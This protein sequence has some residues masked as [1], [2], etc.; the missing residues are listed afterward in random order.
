MRG[1]WGAA[2]PGPV[3]VVTV[4]ALA[5][6]LSSGLDAARLA[7]LTAAVFCGQL[8]VGLSNDAID[9]ERD[10]TVGRGD[11]PVASGAVGVRTALG[12]AIAAAGVALVLSA[13]LGPAFLA[14][15]AIALASAWLYN[16]WA[17]GTA[18]SIAPFVVSFGLFPSFATLAA[19]VPVFA[20]AWASIAGGALGAAMHLTN[21]LPDLDDDAATGV[22]GLPHRLGIR[23]SALAAVACIAIGALAVLLGPARGDL[24]AVPPIAWP[25]FAA[26]VLAALAVLVRALRGAP[27]RILFRLAMLAALLL[28]AQLVVAGGA[29][30]P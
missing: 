3:L 11:K 4:L 6:G 1:L 22:R 2:H 15:H 29:L 12:V 19:A 8:S 16:A 23:P 20:P 13:P 10:R 28:A 26:A 5:L 7:L 18:L 27:G 24:A 14:A 25:F 17:K 21:V 30:R 9:A